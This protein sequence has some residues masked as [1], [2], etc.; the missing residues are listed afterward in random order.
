M[1]LRNI[2]SVGLILSLSACNMTTPDQYFDTAVLNANAISHFGGKEIYESLQAAPQ[3]YD[4][5]S[6]KMVT[7]TYVDCVKMKIQ[8]PEKAYN[9]VLAL[10]ETAETKPMLD[11]SKDLFS[12]AVDKEKNGYL[13]I[14]AM[15]DANQPDDSIKQAA[16]KFDEQYQETFSK[17]YDK[18]M[19]VGKAFADKNHI[20]VEF[21][22]F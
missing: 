18:L 4:D 20:K 2:L 1:N 21:N 3:A 11:A 22:K 17:K 16:I 14:A 5:K 8:Y 10:K 12:F 6:K 19:E 15:K 7:S 9:D 13:A